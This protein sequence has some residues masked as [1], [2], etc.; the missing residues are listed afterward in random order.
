MASITVK[1][2]TRSKNAQHLIGILSELAKT[3]KGISFVKGGEKTS[4]SVQQG[5]TELDLLKKGKII[6]KPAREFLSEI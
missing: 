5:L 1:I 2:D 3:D 4:K 6:P